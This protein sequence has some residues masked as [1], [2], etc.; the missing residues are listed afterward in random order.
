MHY[1]WYKKSCTL[2]LDWNIFFGCHFVNV[3]L[4]NLLNQCKCTLN[5]VSTCKLNLCCTRIIVLVRCWF[6]Q[7]ACDCL[8]SPVLA[9]LDLVAMLMSTVKLRLS[10][11]DECSLFFLYS[12]CI[13]H[14][15]C[16]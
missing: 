12:S 4:T 5:A 11:I 8:S 2:A 7:F 14:A 1:A 13:K 3:M 15:M 9:C 10:F 16:P 6:T